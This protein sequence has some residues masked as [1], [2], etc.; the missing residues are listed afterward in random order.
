MLTFVQTALHDFIHSYVTSEDFASIVLPA[1]EKAL[2]RSPEI[3]LSGMSVAS[4]P[5]MHTHHPFSDLRIP[6]GVLPSSRR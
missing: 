2:L 5:G 1:M 4:S 6:T 3:S